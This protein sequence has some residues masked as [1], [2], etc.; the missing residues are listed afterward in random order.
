MNNVRKI[1]V[2]IAVLSVF[3]AQQAFAQVATTLH[4]PLVPGAECYPPLIPVPP[5]RLPPPGSGLIPGRVTPGMIGPPTLEPWIPAIPSN[6]IDSSF[7]GIGLPISPPIALPPGVWGPLLTPFIPP[8]S[9]TP[10]PAPGM[11]KN[12]NSVNPAELTHVLPAGGLPGTGGYYT[13]IPKI[14][15]LGTQKT[16]QYER[17][18]AWSILGGGGNSQDEVTETGPLA[19]YGLPNGVPTGAGYNKGPAGSNIDNYLK[20][21]DLGGGMRQKFGTVVLSNGKTVQDLNGLNV[22]Y[23]NGVPSLGA[24]R[25]TEFGQGAPLAFTSVGRNY[26]LTTD[27]G[28]PLTPQCPAN[29][30]PAEP[31]HSIPQTA[32]ETNF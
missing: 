21:I 1:L 8:S 7:T 14:R 15:R 30:P 11:L 23:G 24:T 3:C 18:G 27:F 26:S 29:D 25:S 4:D 20:S 28:F 19:G 12:I 17:R 32:V 2:T 13:T 5:G 9:S 10:G 31:N 22:L 6:S 16:A